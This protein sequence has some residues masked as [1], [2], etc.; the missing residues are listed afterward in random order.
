MKYLFDL[1]QQLAKP[2]HHGWLSRPF[3]DATLLAE[4]LKWHREG[5]MGSH[6]QHEVYRGMQHVMLLYIHR[7]DVQRDIAESKQRVATWR[8]RN[9]Q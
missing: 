5:R 6:D 9:G 2:V 8:K 7:L 1:A 4:A 3:A